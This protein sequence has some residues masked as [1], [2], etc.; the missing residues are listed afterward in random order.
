MKIIAPDL[1]N[2]IPIGAENAISC[3]QL[4]SLCGCSQRD[5]RRDVERL[6]REGV[7]ILSSCSCDRGGYYRPR[8]STE[9][10]RYFKR[11]LSRISHV[12]AAL[13]PFKRYLADLPIEGQIAFALD[14]LLESG[15][16]CNE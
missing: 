13:S 1:L 9:I 16:E 8:D 4:A 5:I 12:W 15:G 11:Q 3:R 10:S 7:L 14:E 6:R 2:Y